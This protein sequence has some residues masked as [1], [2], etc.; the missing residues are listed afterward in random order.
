MARGEQV[1]L[2]SGGDP[3]GERGF[4]STRLEQLQPDVTLKSFLHPKLLDW[5]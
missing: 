1:K 3:G 5:L 4:T 2:F